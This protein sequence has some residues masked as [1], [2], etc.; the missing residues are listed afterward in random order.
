[1]INKFAIL[2]ENG[3]DKALFK[4]LQERLIEFQTNIWI[5]ADRA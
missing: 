5:S 1:M 3:P 2:A 4:Y